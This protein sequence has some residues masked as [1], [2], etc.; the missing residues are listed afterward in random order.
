MQEHAGVVVTPSI[1]GLIERAFMYLANGIPVHLSGQPGVGKTTLALHLAHR[2]GRSVHLLHGDEVLST[3]ELVGAPLGF[4]RRLVV[5]EFIR[6]VH[7]REESLTERWVANRLAIACRS[8]GVMVYDEFT[9]SRPEANNV[10]LPVLEER[11]LPLPTAHGDVTFLR[12]HPEFRLILTSNPGEQ[13]GVHAV[14]EALLD[15]VVTLTLPGYGL[16]E[17]VS[18]AAA[19]TGITPD[20]AHTL[21]ETIAHWAARPGAR[22]RGSLLR[23]VLMAARI[24]VAEGI[25]VDPADARLRSIAADLVGLS[26]QTGEA[27]EGE[28]VG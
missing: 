13:A 9:R 7:R 17:M 8:G 16:D 10:L 3:T 14:Q 12:V 15:R 4:T 28:M 24:V 11:I 21:V 25:P 23:A 18:I 2:L 22:P 6:S 26:G 19:R 20:Q 1:A 5:D 27:R